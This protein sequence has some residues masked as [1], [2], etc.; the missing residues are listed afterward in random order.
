[1]TRLLNPFIFSSF[2]KNNRPEK[3]GKAVF[4]DD[5]KSIINRD[6][7]GMSILTPNDL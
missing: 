7:P 2:V 6:K 1:M 5:L 3:A 4:T